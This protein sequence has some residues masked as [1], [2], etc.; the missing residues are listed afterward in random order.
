MKILCGVCNDGVEFFLLKVVQTHYTIRGG[1]NV[2]QDRWV[3][4]GFLKTG[5]NRFVLL[6]YR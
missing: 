4:L 2:K 3:S 5:A 1:S 6:D